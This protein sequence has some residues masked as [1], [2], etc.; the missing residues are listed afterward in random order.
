MKNLNFNFILAIII[1]QFLFSCGNSNEEKSLESTK[2]NN[3]LAAFNW[4]AGDWEDRT[5]SSLTAEYWNIESDTVIRGTGMYLVKKDTMFFERLSIE[6]KDGEIYYVP[7]VNDQNN[8]LPV[9]FKLTAMQDT[10]FIFENP[11][12]DFPQKIVYEFHQPDILF[13]YIEGSDE[14]VYSKQEFTYKRV[15]K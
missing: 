4:L 9:Y 14:G 1:S 15:K 2:L 3:K 12:H 6:L 10:V 5:D 13:A 8:Q 11:Q 7:I